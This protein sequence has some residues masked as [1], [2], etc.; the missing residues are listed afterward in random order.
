MF[1]T[2]DT[3][4]TRVETCTSETTKVDDAMKIEGRNA[5]KILEQS[6]LQGNMYLVKRILEQENTH[7]TNFYFKKETNVT[8]FR[9]CDTP[10]T[11]VQG[12]RRDEDRRM[13]R[14]GN[15]QIKKHEAEY[16]IS[17]VNVVESI[18]HCNTYLLPVPAVIRCP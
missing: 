13:E 1:R 2:C 17:N 8:M 14:E 18:K 3:P 4:F 9:N 11:R 10:F 6:C 15:V 16:F 5:K 7:N 12:R